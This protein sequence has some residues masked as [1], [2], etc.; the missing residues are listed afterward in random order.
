MVSDGHV[1]RLNEVEYP[2][3]AERLLDSALLM[4]AGA[5]GFSA[6]SGRRPGAGLAVTFSILTATVAPGAGVIYDSDFGAGGPWRFALPVSKSVTLA[7][8]PGAGLVRRDLIIARI[9]DVEG[10]RELKIEAVEGDAS[11]TPSKPN[12]PPLS[13]ELGVADVGPSGPVSFVANTARTV[14]AGGIL[15]VATTAERDGLEAPHDGQTVWN[16]QAKRLETF[17]A[18]WIGGLRLLGLRLVTRVL[19]VSVPAGQV[20]TVP[21]QDFTPAFPAAPTILGCVPNSPHLTAAVSTL[22]ASAF[23]VQ[24]RNVHTNNVT[25]ATITVTFLGSV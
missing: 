8:R 22:S 7:A 25:G 14:A 20:S 11:A 24:T 21:S 9:Y 15:P 17:D 16:A 18:S 23:Q 1:S 12:L 2:A 5:G 6:R 4:P 13:L 19:N 10:Q 3:A